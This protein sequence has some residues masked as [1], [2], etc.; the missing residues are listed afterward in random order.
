MYKK[1]VNINGVNT[2]N[3]K[4]LTHEEM[5]SLFKKYKE[6]DISAKDELV[7]GNLKLVLSILKI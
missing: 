5:I 3:L 6:G 7:S 2:N 1:V 4:V